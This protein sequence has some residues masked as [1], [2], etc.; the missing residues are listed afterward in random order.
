MT[1]DDDLPPLG[2]GEILAEKYRVERVLGVGGVG[3]VVAAV[4][5][6]LGQ[7]VALKFLRK[8]AARDEASIER[9]LREARAV[10]RLKSQHAIRVLDVGKLTTGEPYMVM[11]M[12]EGCDF[13]TLLAERGRLPAEE[14]VSYV[15]Q[16]CEA[17]AEAHAAGVVHRDLKPENLFLTTGVD[18]KPF[19]K[20]LD[21]GLVKETKPA[22]QSDSGKSLTGALVM[23]TPEYMS[24]EQ[25]KS[26]R[27]VD[28]RADIWSI[29][30]VLYELVSGRMPF[31]G[32]T[33]PDLIAA[34][35]RDAPEPLAK[36]APG[37]PPGLRDVIAKCLE[38]DPEKRFSKIAKLAAAL[39]E[40]AA[41]APASAGARL[42]LVQPSNA[43]P[44]TPPTGWRPDTTA[45]RNG[46][47]LAAAETLAEIDTKP[48]DAGAGRSS[49]T[50]AVALVT[51]LALAAIAIAFVVHASSPPSV[52]PA[53]SAEPP[54]STSPSA[55]SSAAP[56]VTLASPS[57]S[58]SLP[59][60]PSATG[61][62]TDVSPPS[63]S[64]GTGKA[65]P[66]GTRGK[67]SGTDEGLLDTR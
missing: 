48:S 5:E 57:S 58:T 42:G 9:F 41:P 4:H 33:L 39:D 64:H 52:A 31:A 53:A 18:R 61:R 12:L 1:N 19:V 56:V 25:I 23:G 13:A 27:D 10:V 3:V 32:D 43:P 2:E 7:K 55:T 67:D 30:V 24:P 36:I 38:K 35:V 34:I 21:F 15:L 62:S 45:L 26:T 17:L 47:S 66:R 49:K 29:G 22:P 50:I 46:G 60:L 63:P 51:V 11:E 20:V 28:A 6:T 40:F 16:A 8:S 65:T 44:P 14:A 37:V 59:N 54:P